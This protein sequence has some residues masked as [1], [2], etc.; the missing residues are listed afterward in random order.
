M[1]RVV[2]KGPLL[3][4][5]FLTQ[6]INMYLPNYVEFPIRVDSIGYTLLARRR[7]EEELTA[8]VV[9][10]WFHFDPGVQEGPLPTSSWGA[11]FCRHQ[12]G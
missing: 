3:Y 4:Y 6:I 9:T 5:I 11:A 10:P 7:G 8:T 2:Q 12:Y 1:V